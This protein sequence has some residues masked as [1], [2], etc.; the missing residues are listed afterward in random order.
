MNTD[1]GHNESGFMMSVGRFDKKS[2]GA[3]MTLDF[4]SG[5]D[6]RVVRWSL[7]LGSLLSVEPAYS[8]SL[9]APLS[10]LHVLSLSNI[11]ENK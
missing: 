10:C 11:K 4:C 1:K 5:Y 9:S 8:L 7:T 2:S 3:S 6:P